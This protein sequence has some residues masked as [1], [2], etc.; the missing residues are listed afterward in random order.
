MIGLGSSWRAASAIR[1]VPAGIGE[2]L[3]LVGVAIWLVL[4]MLYAAKWIA[5]RNAALAEAEN[6]IQCCFIGLAGVAT[7]LVSLALIPYSRVA[8]ILI[9]AMGAIFTALFAL[10]RTGV[11]WR[12]GRDPTTT[13]AVLFLPTV[14]GSFVTAIVAGALGYADWGQLA[15]GAG[16]FS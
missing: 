6:S 10:W 3:N 5:D 16:F 11:L 8:A 2:A 15:F 13:T 1:A 4:V 14:A 7:M 12:G 9:F